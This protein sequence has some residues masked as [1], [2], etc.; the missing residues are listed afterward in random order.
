LVVDLFR[1]AI[2]IEGALWWVATTV[3]TRAAVIEKAA[4][5]VVDIG[6][7]VGAIGVRDAIRWVACTIPEL[8]TSIHELANLVIDLFRVV[9]VGVGKAFLWIEITVP[10]RSAGIEVSADFIILTRKF[11]RSVGVVVTA[12]SG[13]LEWCKANKE[14]HWSFS[15]H[16]EVCGEVCWS[17]WS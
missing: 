11:V 16:D 1:V 9:A 7:T 3:A 15:Q 4:V 14:G 2:E 10:T 13:T 8:F 17:A 6:P 5:R 12:L